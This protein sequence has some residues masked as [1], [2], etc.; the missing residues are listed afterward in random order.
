M[1]K[2]T[3]TDKVAMNI[4]S[5]IPDINKVNATDMN[6]IKTVV[7]NNETKIL[8]AVIDTAPVQC[9]TGDMYFNTTTDLIYTATGTNT[10]GTTGTT[11][12]ANTIYVV[13]DTQ[14]TYSYDGNTLISVGGGTDFSNLIV[15]GTDT[16]TAETKLQIETN[17][18]DFQGLEIADSYNTA[19]NVAYSCNYING[20]VAFTGT[21][22]GTVTLTTSTSGYNYIEV[23]ATGADGGYFSSGKLPLE[24]NMLIS[25]ITHSLRD[26]ENTLCFW[27]ST[28]KLTNNTLVPQTGSW[29]YLPVGSSPGKGSG[30]FVNVKKV[31][32]YK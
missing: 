2:I 17:D 30:N 21:E 7:N 4:N 18:L 29:Y 14:S 12:T 10:W 8:L 3:Y 16:P 11:P 9:S 28:L 32:L 22:S 15:V 26:S 13:F 20:T 24:E 5:D 31:I 23:I 27:L 6:E 19:N 25:L 1:S